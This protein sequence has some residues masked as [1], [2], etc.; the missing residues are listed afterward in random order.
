MTPPADGRRDDAHAT[1]DTLWAA[2][3]GNAG[4]LREFAAALAP[5]GVRLV[6]AAALGVGPFPPED[7]TTYEENAMLKAAFVAVETGRV[8]IADDSGL[9]VD[10]LGGEPG[11]H[12]A[13]FGGDLEDGERIAYLLQLLRR[14]PDAARTARFVS[15]VVVAAPQGDVKLFRGV[16]E[17]T[18][19]QGPRG[20]DG[21]GYDPVFR[22][23]DLGRSFGE[24]SLSE[25]ERVS[26]RGRALREVLAWLDTPHGRAFSVRP[27]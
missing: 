10:A 13:R 25:K 6:S 23:A 7:A 11:V 12:S 18:I 9:E 19:L 26:H 1:S 4:K 21:F 27:D 3:T 17:G 14:V 20:D 15:V 22:S 5:A 8:A 24:A 2:A 16:C